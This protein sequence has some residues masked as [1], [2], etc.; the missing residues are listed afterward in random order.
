MR[1]INLL[2]ILMIGILLTACQPSTPPPSNVTSN[3]SVGGI[4]LSF[5]GDWTVFAEK[6]PIEG[7]QNVTLVRFPDAQQDLNIDQFPVIRVSY[8]LRAATALSAGTSLDVVATRQAETLAER[9]TFAEPIVT[10]LDLRPVVIL[11]GESSGAERQYYFIFIDFEAENGLVT[12]VLTAPDDLSAYE[13]EAR[14]IA[15][16]IRLTIKPDS[17]LPTQ[18]IAPEETAF[19][20]PEQTG[21]FGPP[22]ATTEI[23]PESTAEA[24]EAVD[25]TS[26]VAP[27]STAETAA[28][29]EPGAT[30]EAAA[31]A[32][33]ATTDE[34]DA[35]EVVMAPSPE[36]IVIAPS[37]VATL[38]PNQIL[39]TPTP[40]TVTRTITLD[41]GFTLVT[42]DGWVSTT[43]GQNFVGLTL[44]TNVEA[45]M[46][47]NEAVPT[48]EAFISVELGTAPEMFSGSAATVELRGR[49]E[50]QIAA[51]ANY[52]PPL[53]YAEITEFE[54]KGQP[55]ASILATSQNYDQYTLLVDMGA[56]IF[57]RLRLTTA[58]GEGETFIPQALEVAESLSPAQQ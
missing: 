13:A 3:D 21:L 9:A 36:I 23:L 38:L 2:I 18:T 49:L 10:Q 44:G 47:A 43:N 34:A 40:I 41:N 45:A 32:E 12:L 17:I 27:E 46:L 51:T 1:Q 54:I 33:P 15:A 53:T 19:I 31:T 52:R 5:P 56:G 50:A 57:A 55:A 58:A 28:T 14:T 42:L 29:E 20:F 4:S 8:E 24:T 11:K 6:S 37:G 35:T 7:R 25:A 22:D 26:E 39:V 30:S 16:T 48:D